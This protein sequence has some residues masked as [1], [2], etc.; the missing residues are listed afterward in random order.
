MFEEFQEGRMCSRRRCQT[1]ILP[2]LPP[3]HCQFNSRFSPCQRFRSKSILLRVSSPRQESSCLIRVL[4]L[5]TTPCLRSQMR[6]YWF[7]H[8]PK[9]FTLILS[10]CHFWCANS[11]EIGARPRSVNSPPF[12]AR[13]W[14]RPSEAFSSTEW[15]YDLCSEAC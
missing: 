15:T 3:R 2:H 13:M 12:R 14:N 7:E 8:Q 5:A 1:R 4:L 11:V 9:L 6:V 10:C